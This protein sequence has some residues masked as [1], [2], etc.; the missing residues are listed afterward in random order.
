MP[1]ERIFTTNLWSSE[2]GHVSGSCFHKYIFKLMY[3]YHLYGLE[4]VAAYWDQVVTLNHWQKEGIAQLMITK[5][6]GTVNGK[7]IGMLGFAYGRRPTASTR[8][9]RTTRVNPRRSASAAI[10]WRR[11]QFCRLWARR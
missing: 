3:L 10:C 8:R 6:F 11:G 4:E 1:T 2:E 9:I 5:R 7:R